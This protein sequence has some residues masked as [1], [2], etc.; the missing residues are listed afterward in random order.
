MER[1][2][3]VG[4]N[5]EKDVWRGGFGDAECHAQLRVERNVCAGVVGS[6]DWH[7]QDDDSALLF[8]AA[9]GVAQVHG[10]RR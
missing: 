6:F 4:G 3:V 5:S 1:H 9:V 8:R 2:E 7:A 10:G